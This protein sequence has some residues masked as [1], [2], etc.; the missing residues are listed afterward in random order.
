MA[1]HVSEGSTDVLNI[2]HNKTEEHGRICSDSHTSPNCN[3]VHRDHYSR[4][5]FECGLAG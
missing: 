5:F 2:P 1:E 3:S 4:I